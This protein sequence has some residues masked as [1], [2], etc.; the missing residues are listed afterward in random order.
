LGQP[1]LAR[2]RKPLAV[3]AGSLCGSTCRAGHFDV[4]LQTAPG[5]NAKKVPEGFF[6]GLS[7]HGSCRA[8][9]SVGIK[10]P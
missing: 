9:G 3:L 5:C 8:A 6:D 7:G 1:R 2:I 10:I 4:T